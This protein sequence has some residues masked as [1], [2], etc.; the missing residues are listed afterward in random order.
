MAKWLRNND[1]LSDVIVKRELPKQFVGDL[2][3]FYGDK[4]Y[5]EAY[6]E[7]LK[8]IG[9]YYTNLDDRA[10]LKKRWLSAFYDAME[11]IL[12]GEYRECVEIASVKKAL[13]IRIDVQSLPHINDME[14]LINTLAL[15][16]LEML[17]ATLGYMVIM[18]LAVK[19]NEYR[20][21]SVFTTDYI[22]TDF[23]VGT[24]IIKFERLD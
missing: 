21:G 7:P 15:K 24:G 12:L 16:H 14:R 23:D 10:N 5:S 6:I 17:S 9:H 22:L 19:A 3:G 13:S 11:R 18:G 1:E 20:S 2:L 4:L 8:I